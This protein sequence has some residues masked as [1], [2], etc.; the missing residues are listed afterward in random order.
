MPLPI[1]HSAIPGSWFSPE[2]LLRHMPALQKEVNSLQCIF[3]GFPPLLERPSTQVS[4]S[5]Q[6][7]HRIVRNSQTTFKGIQRPNHHSAA[8]GWVWIAALSPIICALWGSSLYLSAR[9]RAGLQ[10]GLGAFPNSGS[11]LWCAGQDQQGALPPTHRPPQPF[12]K[13]LC[14]QAAREEG[15]WC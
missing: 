11:L 9:C 12:G 14:A 1:L 13:L 4:I 10:T 3:K 8:R 7:I 15:G 5:F 6:P 2:S